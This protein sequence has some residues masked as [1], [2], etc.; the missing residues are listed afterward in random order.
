M[1]DMTC[2]CAASCDKRWHEQH[3]NFQIFIIINAIWLLP[4]LLQMLLQQPKAQ[5]EARRVTCKS[6][7]LSTPATALLK[8]SAAYL[9][10]DMLR[11]R[12]RRGRYLE[13]AAH[14]QFLELDGA[15]QVAKLLLQQREEKTHEVRGVRGNAL[16]QCNC[17]RHQKQQQQQRQRRRRQQ[18]QHLDIS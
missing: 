15:G 12:T 3:I 10:A 17:N 18:Q 4:A 13:A 8:H 1:S 5:A 14:A 6:N 11:A 16:D 9:H 2:C 7:S